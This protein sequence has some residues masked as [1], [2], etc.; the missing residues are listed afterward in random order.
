MIRVTEIFRH[1]THLKELMLIKR[2]LL[3][4]S[5]RTQYTMFRNRFLAFKNNSL[6][7]S[8]YSYE[9]RKICLRSDLSSF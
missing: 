7:S 3:P 8:K 2:K 5:S 1:Q 4:E 6:H 9:G